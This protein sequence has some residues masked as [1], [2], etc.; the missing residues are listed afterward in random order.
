MNCEDEACTID[1]DI[2]EQTQLTYE[3]VT[4]RDYFYLQ[5]AVELA[6]LAVVEESRGGESHQGPRA[7]CVI[8]AVICSAAFLECTINGLYEDAKRHTRRTNFHKA[9]TSV[10]GE[11]FERLPILAKYQLALTLARKDIFQ[12]GSEPYQSAEAVIELRNAIAHPKEILESKKN[13][14]KLENR[15]RGRYKFGVEREHRKEFFPD[16][17]LSADCAKWATSAA[18]QFVDEFKRRL[19]PTAYFFG[20]R[21]HLASA[22]LSKLGVVKDYETPKQ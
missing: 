11:A 16:R 17:C 6:L 20:S 18:V 12:T 22:V 5:S 14:Q 15:L 7:A 10:W 2:T 3:I 8:G 21:D 1:S 13:Q 19:P 9:L 4:F